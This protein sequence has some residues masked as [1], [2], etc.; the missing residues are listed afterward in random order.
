LAKAS[1]VD[2]VF[3]IKEEIIDRFGSLDK[4]SS[5]YIELILIK[6][7]SINKKY[8]KNTQL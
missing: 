2:E 6:V 8:I 3:E 5:Q 4:T 7:L 1:S